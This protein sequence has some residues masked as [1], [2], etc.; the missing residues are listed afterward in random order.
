[1][2]NLSRALLIWGLGLGMMAASSAEEVRVVTVHEFPRE[3]QR[4]R[5]VRWLDDTTLLL[6]SPAQGIVEW[7]L[8][9]GGYKSWIAAGDNSRSLLW[10]PSRLG[11][12][13]R[14]G[15]TSAGIYYVAWWPQENPSNLHSQ[16]FAYAVD[17]DVQGDQLI[18]LGARREGMEFAPDGVIAWRTT[19]A[20]DSLELKPAFYSTDGP[21][22]RRMNDCACLDTGAVRFFRDGSYVLVPGVEPGIY[23][24]NDQGTLI[25]TWDTQALGIDAD[26]RMEEEQ[27]LQI[28]AEPELRIQWLSNHVVVEEVLDLGGKIALILRQEQEGTIHWSLMTLGLDGSHRIIPL[29]VTS[30]TPGMRLDGDARGGRLAVVLH[31]PYRMEGPFEDVPRLMILETAGS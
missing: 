5:D 11:A 4:T 18:V 30:K 29:P 26:C 6:A 8:K 13:G 20:G 14:F 28:S 17:L 27:A 21:H 19:L 9:E 15:V 7:S 25:R 24:Y 31:N 22:V 1:M 16:D 23:L 12:S 2:G 10:A 3:V